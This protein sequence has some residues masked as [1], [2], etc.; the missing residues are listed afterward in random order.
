MSMLSTIALG[1]ALADLPVIPSVREWT[2]AGGTCANPSAVRTVLG[3]A[4]VAGPEDYRLAI[5]ADGVTVAAKTEAGARHGRTT[6]AQLAAATGGRLPTGTVVDGP[7]YRVRG[8][9]LDVA[10]KWYPLDFLDA[11]VD[12]LAHYKFNEL[13]LHLNDNG[14]GTNWA[15]RVECETYPG[16]AS[17]D[18]YSKADFRAFVKRAAAKGV[19]VVPEIDSPAHARAFTRYRPDFASRAYGD[20][21][22]DLHSPD[23]VPF[24]A[25]LFAEYCG[26][27]DPVFAG[28]NVSVGTDEYD[29]REA[30]AFRAYTDALLKTVRRLG[31][32]PRAWGALTH[33]QGRTPVDATGVTLDIWHNGYHEPLQ[34]LKEGFGLICVPDNLV[35]LVPNAGYY[36]DYLNCERLFRIWEPSEFEEVHVDPS[37]PQLAGGKFAFWNDGG[38]A[39][40]DLDGTFARL[41][42]AI[43]TLGEK[44][45]AGRRAGLSWEAFTRRAAQTC[46]APN[47]RRVERMKGL[48]RVYDL[49]TGRFEELDAAPPMGWCD[50]DRADALV[51]KRVRDGLYA[52]VFETTQAQWAQ[53][54]ADNPSAEHAPLAPV[55]HVS[56]V[57]AKKWL[58]AL[59]ARTGEAGFDIP[60][61]EEWRALRAAKGLDGL[62]NGV[63]EWISDQ[64]PDNPRIRFCVDGDRAREANYETSVSGNDRMG[65]RLVLRTARARFPFVISYDAPD[66]VV[67]MKGLLGGP[68]GEADRVFVKDGHFATAKGPIR[69]NATNLTGPA[70]MPSKPY[71]DRLADRLARFGINCVRLHF[72]DCQQGYG[73][74]MQARQPGLLKPSDDPF[75]FAFDAAQFDR[76]DYLVAAFKRRGIYV[77]VNL[78]VARFMNYLIEGRASQKGLTWLD[79]DIIASEKRYARAFLTHRN[80]YTGLTWAEDPVVAMVELNNEDAAFDACHKALKEGKPGFAKVIAE[81]EI[82]Y[83]KEMKAL[84]RDEL[85]CRAPLAGTQVTYTSAHV[86]GVL[87]YLDAHEY[88]CHPSPVRADWLVPDVAQVNR[89]TDNC[90]AWLASRRARGYPFTVSEYNNPY[91]NRTGAEGPLLLHAYG[92]YQ[93]WDGVF[94]YT[95]DNRAD[96]EP[97]HVAYFFSMVAR[98]DVLAHLPACAALY[99]RG[100]V[101]PARRTLA[102]GGT[103]AD[104]L[105]RF[106]RNRLIFDDATQASGGKVPYGTGLVTGLDFVLEGTERPTDVPALGPVLVSDTGELEWNVSAPDAGYVAI[107]TANT[108]AFTGFVR[109]RTF[110]LGDGVTLAVGATARDWATV[111][112]VSKDAN[113]F[114][115]DGKARLLLAVTGQAHNTGARFTEHPQKDGTVKV[116]T[117][118]ADWGTGP[119]E[120]EGVPATVTLPAKAA[121]CWALD[122]RGERA[123]PVP[124]R[125]VGGGTAVDVGPQYRTVWYEIETDE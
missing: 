115:R 102:V 58:A 46:E 122:E 25:R 37:H 79:R 101:K 125:A 111:S 114:G 1:A 4:D 33:A 12:V 39:A 54:D 45:W 100:D 71:A 106:D 91:P 57:M 118:G 95:Y 99:L 73:S 18:C 34:A 9:V 26:G 23:V 83:L 19:D 117:R 8:L 62:A 67:N 2:P 89:P 90:I 86:N 75:D 5:T 74:F 50:R 42:P 98:T 38:E 28:P 13:H 36:Y 65:F 52:A 112:L 70:N 32:R 124:V 11:L 92:A 94:L 31:K 85:G 63:T 104:Y 72:L 56:Y 44:M 49:K 51:L 107:R 20:T 21:H 48:Y 93:G 16:L 123:G 120:V 103:F 40:V 108:K 113:G 15:F 77:N 41:F 7:K 116:S 80:P 55:D 88:W 60:T 119:F 121:R 27:D 68:I 30:E 61:E 76:L 82:A 87:D 24:M 3:A 66:N 17:K 78:H 53:L 59:A 6:L 109:G 110:D 84:I 43:Q 96:S 47:V 81:R 97:D 35:Y 29:K 64:S 22:L 14:P 105:A 69:F 10:R